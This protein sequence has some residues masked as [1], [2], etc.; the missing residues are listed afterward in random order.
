MKNKLK[1]L[2]AVGLSVSMALSLASCGKSKKDTKIVLDTYNSSVT[3]LADYASLTVGASVVAGDEAY[4]KQLEGRMLNSEYFDAD[5]THVS[6]GSG[7]VEEYD[8]VNIDYTG[9]IDGA[10][11]ENGEDKDFNLFIGSDTFIDGFEDGLVGHKAGETV[12]LELTFPE[13]YYSEDLAGK[14]VTFDVTI[15][16]IH[17]ITDK[18]I[19]DNKV[20]ITHFLYTY[21]YGYEAPTS[22][23]QF[24]SIVNHRYKALNV[25]TEL[26]QT[27]YDET[28]FD[29]D[30]EELE[31]YIQEKREPYEVQA[32]EYNM[33][34]EEFLELNK[35][36]E[37]SFKA[38]CETSFKQMLLIREIARQEGLYVMS[39]E[40]DQV[41]KAE[42]ANS[43]SFDSK[44]AFEAASPKEIT[45][46]NILAGKV[47]K[48]ISDKVT[49]VEDSETTTH[50]SENAKETIQ[51]TTVEEG[52]EETTVVEN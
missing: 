28:E 15:N 29:V 24:E 41:V 23:S 14:D 20:G 19:E 40:Y 8:L 50:I 38:Y 34:F 3:S 2:L 7:T 31:Q 22:I 39:S 48:A 5:L 9:Y 21:Y 32:K 16:Y 6:R 30:E 10:K 35:T 18:F 43:S 33:T 4:I 37:D 11:F 17:R 27:I 13:E 36:D 49:I 52:E 44:E 45:A 51:E 46:G 47:Y 42:V 26:L 12:S 25:T 1:K